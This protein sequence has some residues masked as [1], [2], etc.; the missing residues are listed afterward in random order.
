MGLFGGNKPIWMSAGLSSVKTLRYVKACEDQEELV[1][2]VLNG[3]LDNYKEAALLNI[4]DKNVL[5]DLAK[6]LDTNLAIKALL[7][8]EDEDGLKSIIDNTDKEDLY[9]VS[10]AIRGINDEDYLYNLAK[11]N[12]DKTDLLTECAKKI[13][14]QS[15][16]SE[17]GKKWNPFA[18]KYIAEK[19]ND[20]E[21]LRDMVNSYSSEP[22]HPG[23]LY[24]FVEAENEV[25]R[26]A[27]NRLIELKKK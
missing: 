12:L 8:A 15:Y 11:E 16:L 13:N 1:Q 22:P 25:H 26:I 2:I 18:A 17:L 3:K 9:S 20:V 23:Q 19:T 5:K 4:K 14:N 6:K 21:L 27:K 7:Q 24:V 10:F